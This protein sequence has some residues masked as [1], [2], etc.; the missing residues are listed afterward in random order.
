V[1]YACESSDP[2]FL[3]TY[4]IVRNTFKL[5]LFYPLPPLS[6]LLSIPRSSTAFTSFP[7]SPQ[8]LANAY[9]VCMCVFFPNS[10]EQTHLS[11]YI[12]STLK[13][14]LIEM[15]EFFFLKPYL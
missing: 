3:G 8:V 6:N 1:L 7:P 4:N 14:Y 2:S 11:I 10:R 15:K 9:I 5:H 12:I 13:Y